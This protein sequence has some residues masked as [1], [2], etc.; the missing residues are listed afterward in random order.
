MIP[1]STPALSD[2][3]ALF[4]VCISISLEKQSTICALLNKASSRVTLASGA[5]QKPGVLGF[6]PASYTEQRVAEIGPGAWFQRRGVICQN[7]S[8]FFSR[9]YGFCTLCRH[10]S[11]STSRS[12]HWLAR[13]WQQFAALAF[14]TKTMRLWKYRKL[15]FCPSPARFQV[16]AHRVDLCGGCSLCGV[17]TDLDTVDARHREFLRLRV[18]LAQTVGLRLPKQMRFHWFAAHLLWWSRICQ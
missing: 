4:H 13:R 14:R 15:G 16:P 11:P 5:C 6:Q 1:F 7:G 2:C 8:L 10:R 12:T 9:P 17:S 18:H 3:P